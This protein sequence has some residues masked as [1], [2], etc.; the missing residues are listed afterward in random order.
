[1]FKRSFFTTV[2]I[3]LMGAMQGNAQSRRKIGNIVQLVEQKAQDIYSVMDIVKG[4]IYAFVVIIVLVYIIKILADKSA[5][6]D[7]YM[8]AGGLLGLLILGAMM[9]W[10]AESLFS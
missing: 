7:K 9:V 3:A 1:M 8:K 5:G 4:L 10:L 2:A 6:E